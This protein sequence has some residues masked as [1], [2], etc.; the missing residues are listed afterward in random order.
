MM[1]AI[2]PWR[3]VV[4]KP[5]LVNRFRAL[6][7]KT[8]TDVHS[9]TVYGV[10]DLESPKER[11]RDQE[12]VTGPDMSLKGEQKGRKQCGRASSLPPSLCQV[13]RLEPFL[14]TLNCLV[15]QDLM[16]ARPAL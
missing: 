4:G 7:T 2:A 6:R 11:E 14:V 8:G 1:L 13:G 3:A 12:E 15:V 10:W 5:E 9:L 16:C